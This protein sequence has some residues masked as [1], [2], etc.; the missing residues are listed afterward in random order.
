MSVRPDE[1]EKNV[2]ITHS[3]TRD[4]WMNGWRVSDKRLLVSCAHNVPLSILCVYV[5]GRARTHTHTHTM[6]KARAHTYALGTTYLQS[7]SWTM[8]RSATFPTLP[9][10][11][12]CNT[13]YHFP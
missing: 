6:H 7:V 9:V 10:V 1:A 3:R 5:H 4:G 13:D 11:R 8:D 12:Q 2:Q